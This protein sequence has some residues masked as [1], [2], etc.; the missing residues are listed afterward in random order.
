MVRRTVPLSRRLRA[1]RG[2]IALFGV[3]FACACTCAVLMIVEHTVADG[4]GLAVA[5]DESHYVR[6]PESGR[7]ST[8]EVTPG[9]RVAA[10]QVLA[11]VDSPLLN[12]QIASAEAN[13]RELEARLTI[14]ASDR[15]RKFAR[16]LEGARA[17]WLQARVGLERDRALLV[18]AEQDLAR[19]QAPGVLIAAGE[20]QRLEVAR[21]AAR[22]AVQAREAEAATLERNYHEAQSRAGA[23]V[24]D[25]GDAALA[26]AAVQLDAL[27]LMA[28]ANVLKSPVEGVVT[29]P[30]SPYS[31]DGRTDVIDET[32]PV[33]GSWVQ[34]GVP[35]LMVTSPS[36]HEAV[37]FV[38]LSQ[39]RTL[40][41]GVEVSLKSNGQTIAA[42]VA[43]V[44][45]AV[46]P[47]PTRQL[48][49]P[50]RSE[51]AVPV[52]LLVADALVPGEALSVEF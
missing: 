6:V 9:Q 10:G 46:E 2:K 1:A 47:V 31:R 18:G 45:A 39:A 25:A 21:E 4:G 7:I 30:V 22:A 44:G 24:G 34:A 49:D 27:R 48:R 29:A 23:Q 16:D 13:L 11:R 20:V 35:V 5:A 3:W 52:T 26:A 28:D 42:T 38:G 50:T 8:V 40:S 43:A 19:A 17:A 41:P 51:W 12:Q 32:F 14:D 33:P 37:V 15:G 36:T